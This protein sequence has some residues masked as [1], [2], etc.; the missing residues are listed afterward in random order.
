M[1]LALASLLLLGFLVA[2]AD[3]QRD[4]L[5]NDEAWTAWAIQSP[6]IRDT[7]MRVQSDVHPPFYFL[8]LNIW[9]R[10]E[11]DSVFAL[12]LPSLFFGLIG[13]S[14]TYAVGR[15][16]FDRRTGIIALVVLGTASFFVYYTREARMYTLL[17][18]LAG[19]STLLY[20]RWRERATFWRTLFYG[21]SMALL[22]YTHYAG[23]L[24]IA[25]HLI[26][27]VLTGF[28]WR[29]RIIN[30]VK[31][32]FRFVL[33]YALALILFVPWLPIFISQMKANPNGPLAIPVATD[34]GAVAALVLIM[35]SGSWVLFILPFIVSRAV[36]FI[37]RYGSAILL[38][39][40][41]LLLTPIMLLALNAWITPVYQVRYTIAMLPAGALLLAYAISN[42]GLPM[43]FWEAI[44]VE[45]SRIVTI[46]NVAVV[47]ILTLIVET[48]LT[49][50]G[51]LWA[52]K[53]PWQ[54]T[55]EAMV[56]ARKLLEPT[57][58]DI[59]PYSPAAYYDRH[60]HI[61]QGISLDLSWRLHT[62]P[63]VRDLV[64]LFDKDPSV[65]VVL[66]VNTAKTWQIVTDLDETRHVG[67]SDSLVNMIFYRFDQ[68]K[69][70]DLGFRFGDLLRY[71]SGPGADRQ[72]TVQAGNQL[73][74][75]IKL[76]ALAP[77][78]GAY[79][80][81]LH[82]IDLT[83][84]TNLAAWDGGIG[85]AGTGDPVNLS[86]CI[87]IPPN[88]P[89]GHD[90]LELVIYNWSNLKR[91]PLIEDGGGRDVSW[92][93]VLMLAAVDVLSHN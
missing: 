73:C 19:L 58:T 45:A 16:L 92:Q 20:L 40:L 8:L 44:H 64:N 7:L 85:T 25:T 32:I 82:L 86:P 56:T 2:I 6:Y 41:W 93:D 35:T 33:P 10:V 59:A 80:A 39:L 14:A 83:G 91:L 61:R 66:P 72:L 12:R 71:V 11:G 55:I 4:S 42:I 36:P 69:G 65:W 78:D 47:V 26:H 81:G 90:H 43:R 50:Y 77:L 9:T 87:S 68:G 3:L 31:Q 29:T 17:L 79:S 57:I 34:W 27:G 48:Q 21:V 60:L 88:T 13:L 49:I 51:D 54:T 22:L 15:R 37:R 74:V 70:G 76:K 67:Y 63:E 89:V 62:A 84:T 38:L 53:P 52:A 24:I 46:Q 1:L 5:W 23:G 30:W 18:A 75:N 28:K